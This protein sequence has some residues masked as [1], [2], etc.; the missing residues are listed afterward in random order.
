MRSSAV[1]YAETAVAAVRDDAT[2]RYALMRRLYEGL[3][4]PGSPHLPYRRAA[5]TFMNWQ[6]RRGL[7]EPTDGAR[8][9]SPWWRAVNEQLLRDLC[10]AR[11][12]HGGHPGVPSSASVLATLDFICRPSAQSWYRAHNIGV[13]SAYLEHEPLAW[14]EGRLERFCVNLVLMRVLYAHT[15][16][17][18]PRLALGWLAPMAPP[19]GDPRLGM[20]GI[21]LSLSRV[22]PA[23]YPI[24][25]NVAR[26]VELEHG[27]GHLLDV[28]VIRPRIEHLYDWSARE[29]RLPGL[30]DLLH[31]G[32]P[33]YAWDSAD[34]EPWNPPPSLLARWALRG[35]R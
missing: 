21:F 2:A 20:T 8:P 10:E 19:L 15:L 12:I 18:A 31:D 13:V 34:H 1:D 33:S 7:L 11:A 17:A 27:F 22:L 16:V 29:L 35:L 14:A 30:R 5:L 6:L 25:E 32:I 3:P 24:G 23:Q 4:Q 9:G 26:F 28:G